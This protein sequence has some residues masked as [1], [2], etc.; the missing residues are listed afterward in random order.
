[1]A[2][3]GWKVA[4]GAAT[5]S[6]G[7]R[8]LELTVDWHALLWATPATRSLAARREQRFPAR[9]MQCLTHLAHRRSLAGSR[10]SQTSRRS[11]DADRRF[12]LPMRE[13]ADTKAPLRVRVLI[14]TAQGQAYTSLE[15]QSVLTATRPV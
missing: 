14:G 3:E 9:S 13:P 5:R 11:E 10:Q 7:P 6:R 15:R 2:A 4:L 12:V 8:T 1:A